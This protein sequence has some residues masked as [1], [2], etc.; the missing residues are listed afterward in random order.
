MP[1]QTAAPVEVTAGNKEVTG[2][3]LLAII[4]QT[5]PQFGSP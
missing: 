1:Q 3:H 4:N 2:S 5:I